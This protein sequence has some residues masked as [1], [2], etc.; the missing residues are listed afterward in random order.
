M[1]YI[2]SYAFIK[3][4]FIYLHSLN[5]INMYGELDGIGHV[6]RPLEGHDVDRQGTTGTDAWPN[7]A[8]WTVRNIF[9]PFGT[10]LILENLGSFR[11]KF[12]EDLEVS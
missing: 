1:I 7:S 11:A 3:F 8:T 2:V 5:F 6:D 4:V 9:E 10:I 12:L